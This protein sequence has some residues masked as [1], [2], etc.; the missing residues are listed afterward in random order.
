MLKLNLKQDF[1]ELYGWIG[2]RKKKNLNNSLTTWHK[3]HDAFN[4]LCKQFPVSAQ[5]GITELGKAH[6][7]FAMSPN[8]PMGESCEI[9][10]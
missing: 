2:Q 3:S 8:S 5:H 9:S 10:K 6:T 4:L 1:W 7:H